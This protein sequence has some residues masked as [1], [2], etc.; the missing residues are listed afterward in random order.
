MGDA[1]RGG[2]EGEEREL[3]HMPCVAC[4]RRH[5]PLTSNSRDERTCHDFL[6]MKNDRRWST[7]ACTFIWLCWRCNYAE[8]TLTIGSSSKAQWLR[9]AISSSSPISWGSFMTIHFTSWEKNTGRKARANDTFVYAMRKNQNVLGS[10][11]KCSRLRSVS[12]QE[13]PRGTS[14]GNFPRRKSSNTRTFA[15]HGGTQD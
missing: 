3:S 13:E 11:N 5:L 9:Y 15:P 2:T 6:R 1:K 8:R 4:H 7:F 14:P 10:T 12:A